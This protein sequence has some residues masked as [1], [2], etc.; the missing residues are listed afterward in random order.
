MDKVIWKRVELLN[1]FGHSLGRGIPS[2]PIAD[3]CDSGIFGKREPEVRHRGVL[4]ELAFSLKEQF[5]FLPYDLDP[6]G[7]EVVELLKGRAP[8]GFLAASG[9]GCLARKASNFASGWRFRT[10]LRDLALKVAGRFFA[11]DSSRYSSIAA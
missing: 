2:S 5:C 10:A 11:A 6:P 1:L 8:G 9:R 3:Y 4:D 7:V